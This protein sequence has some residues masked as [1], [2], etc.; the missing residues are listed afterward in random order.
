[1]DNCVYK[2]VFNICIT[3]GKKSEKNLV[4]KYENVSIEGPL[5]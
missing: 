3:F 2:T 5:L 1:M 4:W